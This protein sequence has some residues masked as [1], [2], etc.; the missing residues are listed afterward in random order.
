LLVSALEAQAEIG[1]VDAV[2]RTAR[3]FLDNLVFQALLE[4]SQEAI[5]VADRT[6]AAVDVRV[7]AGRAPTADRARAE[8][9]LAKVR[10]AGLDAEQELSTARQRL[11]TQW[12]QSRPDFQQV[13]G[14]GRQLPEP[15]SFAVLT[16]GR[17]V[18]H[19]RGFRYQAGTSP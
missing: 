2:A 9:E 17:S 3:L 1:R 4:L 15:D 13:I 11:A 7:R 10:L 18:Y 5:D 12:G 16:P 14:N 19:P 8:A 6:V